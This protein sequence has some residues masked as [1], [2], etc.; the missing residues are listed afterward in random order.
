M[1]GGGGLHVSALVRIPVWLLGFDP[2]SHV[3]EYLA[4]HSDLKAALSRVCSCM[5]YAISISTRLYM[6]INNN[7][8]LLEV[9]QIHFIYPSNLFIISLRRVVSTYG[10]ARHHLSFP[11][12]R[13]Q[14]FF[15]MGFDYACSILRRCSGIST[16]LRND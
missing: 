12:P 13:S 6:W 9:I 16:T 4:P 15:F 8:S 3:F 1:F 11:L 7:T 14:V 10:F 5:A 2:F